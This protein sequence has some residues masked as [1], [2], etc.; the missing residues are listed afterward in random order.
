MKNALLGE[1]PLNMRRLPDRIESDHWKL[2]DRRTSRGDYD[3][4]ECRL[5]IAKFVAEHQER[6]EWHD[7]C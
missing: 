4:A 2:R 1:V 5:A 7:D 6:N 3:E